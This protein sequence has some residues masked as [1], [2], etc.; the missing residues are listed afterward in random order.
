MSIVKDSWAVDI[1]DLPES[2]VGGLNDVP[3]NAC[4]CLIMCGNQNATAASAALPP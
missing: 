4:R 3:C 2:C 1:T